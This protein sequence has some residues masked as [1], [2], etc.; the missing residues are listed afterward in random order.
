MPEPL[1]PEAGRVP[2]LTLIAW[3]LCALCAAV[4]VAVI[5]REPTLNSVP[6][7]SLGVL[8]LPYAPLAALAWWARRTAT[9]RWVALAGV[10]CV[11]ALGA[12]LWLAWTDVPMARLAAP[13]VIPGRQLV[14]VAVVAYVVS[15]A[16]R[17]HG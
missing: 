6:R 14:A 1:A 7:P 16:R 10:V 4:T 8:V 12:A 17:A 9:A 11:F 2:G 13:R 5:L 15:L 3:G